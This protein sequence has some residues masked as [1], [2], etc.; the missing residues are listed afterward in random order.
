MLNFIVY[1]GGLDDDG[2]V[3]VLD[4]VLEF[5]IVTE[6][7]KKIASMIEPRRYHAV[8]LVDVDDVK[9]YFEL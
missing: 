3:A 6:E 5:D 8:S 2:G 9:Q 1:I 4:D 7:W